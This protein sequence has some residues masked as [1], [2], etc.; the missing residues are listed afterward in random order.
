MIFFQI[1]KKCG[2]FSD[3]GENMSIV[4]IVYFAD[5][6]YIFIMAVF[7]IPYQA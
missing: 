3:L 5:Y 1:R 2:I 7:S 4:S 6:I